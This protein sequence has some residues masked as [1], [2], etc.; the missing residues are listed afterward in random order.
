MCV[1]NYACMYSWWHL[2][3]IIESI[4][5]TLHYTT[6]HY[7]T[8]HYIALHLHYI[9]LHFVTFTLHFITFTFALHCNTC[10]YI[11]SRYITFCYVYIALH[12]VTFTLHLHYMTLHYIILH[13][14]TL[15]TYIH[16]LP[17]EP[18]CNY[19]CYTDRL[20][21]THPPTSLLL[22]KFR[23]KNVSDSATW[24][25]YFSTYYI[26]VPGLASRPTCSIASLL[27]Y[28]RTNKTDVL[29]LCNYVH[30]Q[31]CN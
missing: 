29:Y 28:L 11:T 20:T 23:F 27:T 24:P 30:T 8:L 31:I 10:Y 7:T 26:F 3:D 1:C 18:I 17:W 4:Y 9:T 14:N 16:T 13:Y 22:N 12:F 15:H 21:R 5:I 19:V 25:V 2:V 6:L